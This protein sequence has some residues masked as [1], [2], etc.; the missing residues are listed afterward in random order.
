LSRWPQGGEQANDLVG[1]LIVKLNR[2]GCERVVKIT[3]DQ[4]K[5]LVNKLSGFRIFGDDNLTTA[6][7]KD[8]PPGRFPHLV[9]FAP[10]DIGYLP[11][12]SDLLPKLGQYVICDRSAQSPVHFRN[13]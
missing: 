4:A 12:K 9:E 3:R 8:P 13:F 5:D 7:L 1:E 11:S 2:T 6:V 10:G